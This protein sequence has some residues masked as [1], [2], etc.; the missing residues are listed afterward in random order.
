MPSENT[1]Y[2]YPGRGGHSHDGNNSSFI[3][4]SVYSLF[5]FSWG[6]VGDPDRRASQRINYHAFR[7]FIVDT[8]NRSVLEPAGLVLQPGIVNGSAHIISR[9]IEANT[10]AANTLTANEIS[11]NTITSNELVANFVLVNTIIASSDFNGTFDANTF[12]LSNNGTDG[13]A[14]TSAGDAVFTNGFFRGSLE[15]GANDYWYSNGA[16]ALGGNTGIFRNAGGGITLGANVTIQG[17]VVATSVATPGIDIDANGNLTANT[18]A[19]YGNGA[20]VTSSGNFSVDASGNLSAENALIR[21]EISSETFVTHSR[22]NISNNWTVPT[23]LI[24]NAANEFSLNT[25]SNGIRMNGDRW[26]VY[27][28]G[29]TFNTLDFNFA[30]LDFYLGGDFSIDGDFNAYGISTSQ[31]STAIG[32]K[33]VEY[34][35]SNLGGGFPIAFGYDNG[36]GQLRAIVDNNAGVY[37]NLTKTSASDRRL[38]DNIEPISDSVLDK[39]YSIKTYEFDWNEKTPQYIKYSGRGVGVIADELKEL[40]PEAVDDTEAYEGWVHR[41]DEH[42]EGFSVEEMEQFGSDFYEFVPGEGVWKKPKYASVDYTALIPHML[43][44]IKDLNNRVKELEN[45]V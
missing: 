12:T 19:L 40:Y 32:G 37:F 22:F 15:I 39:F 3:D 26:Y 6:E 28:S 44:A 5:D 16:F 33:G 34:Y 7:D 8:V 42:P 35:A 23:V 14:I 9:S 2:F 4:T 25:A 20:I 13:W 1:I 29:S 17:G 27:R 30:T 18:F 31:T 21:G 11:A 45:E 38:K 24:D 10:I 36:S 41:Y 43:T